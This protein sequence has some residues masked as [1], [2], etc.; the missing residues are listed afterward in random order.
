MY[1]SVPEL[2]KG[3]LNMG[4]M[5]HSG[6]F[7]FG[8]WKPDPCL[9][10]SSNKGDLSSFVS[11]IT[12]WYWFSHVSDVVK[13]YF[14]QLWDLPFLSHWCPCHRNIFPYDH[15]MPLFFLTKWAFSKTSFIFPGFR[16]I[17]LW[18]FVHKRLIICLLFWLLTRWLLVGLRLTLFIV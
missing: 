3:C 10:R 4:Q 18:Q 8:S 17:L 15:E 2:S 12:M 16:W 9:C 5:F 14:M 13:S 6:A 7:H 1:Y 11:L